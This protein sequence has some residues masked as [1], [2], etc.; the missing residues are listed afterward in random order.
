MDHFGINYVD[1]IVDI[2]IRIET[3]HQNY[4]I[5]DDYYDPKFMFEDKVRTFCTN[6]GAAYVVK[7][8]YGDYFSINGHSFSNEKKHNNLVNFAMLKTIKLTDPVASGHE[9][10]KILGLSA[11]QLGGG[12]PIMQR[13]GDFRMGKRSKKDTFNFDLYY[14]KPT[15]NVTP[16]DLSLAIPAKILR[17][18]WK[19]MKQLDTI[20]PGVLHPSTIMYYPEIKTYANKPQFIDEYFQAKENIY[21]CG[22]GAGTSRG[23]TAAWCS[24]IRCAEGILMSIGINHDRN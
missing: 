5:V 4:S 17:D 15:L 3:T 16:G 19:A 12:Q 22:D 2:G 13:I 9:F 21:F 24:G 20:V 18:I 7:E 10:A 14:F 11:M 6:S 23:I 1:N 8:K